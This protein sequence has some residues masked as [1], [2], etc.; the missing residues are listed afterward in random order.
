MKKLP[1][2]EKFDHDDP[3]ERTGIT[4]FAKAAE[5]AARAPP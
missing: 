2:V 4:T 3:L 5:L 1:P